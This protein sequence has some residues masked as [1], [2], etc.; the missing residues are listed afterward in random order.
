MRQKINELK[1]TT[2]LEIAQAAFQKDGYASVAVSSIA[3]EAE[4]SI[5][6]IYGFFDNKEGLFQAVHVM[7]MKEASTFLFQLFEQNPDAPK[8]NLRGV[9]HF[10]F[11]TIEEH[12]KSVQEMLI[13]LPFKVGCSVSD[14]DPSLEIYKLISLEIEKLSKSEKLVGVDYLQYSF[15]LRNLAASYIERWAM[16]GDIELISKVDECLDMFLGG[17]IK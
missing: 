17:I 9:L 11:T 12:K 6:T 1:K 2:I 4:V 15:N 13:S 3:K 16:L 5:G 14:E 7:K 8:E 10:Y